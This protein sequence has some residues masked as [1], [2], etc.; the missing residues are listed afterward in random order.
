MSMSS[1]KIKGFANTV[2]NTVSTDGLYFLFQFLQGCK[3]DNRTLLLLC[4]AVHPFD[5]VDV[6]DDELYFLEVK[7]PKTW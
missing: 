2:M 3:S 5:A 1:E 6:Q 4:W 7:M